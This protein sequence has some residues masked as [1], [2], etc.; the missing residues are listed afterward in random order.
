MRTS[1][2]ALTNVSLFCW[3]GKKTDNFG[4]RPA[5]NTDRLPSSG[6][7]RNRAFFPEVLGHVIY[8]VSHLPGHLNY[9]VVLAIPPVTFLPQ[10]N[11]GVSQCKHLSVWS[12]P[13]SPLHR[14]NKVRFIVTE[15]SEVY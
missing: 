7:Y 14:K 1:L 11:G 12:G 8:L 4:L 3:K 9:S 13:V 15:I 6:H 10:E 5:K 2:A